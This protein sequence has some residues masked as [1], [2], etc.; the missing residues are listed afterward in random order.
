MKTSSCLTAIGFF[1]LVLT[2]KASNCSAQYYYSYDD[3]YQRT[4]YQWTASYQ[5]YNPRQY[6]D[7]YWWFNDRN[8]FSGRQM[9]S[10]RWDPRYG[11][12][13]H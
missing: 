10:P 11:W 6:F 1:A 7:R 4:P 13:Y 5:Y 9:I 12:V 3:P 8:R 2:L